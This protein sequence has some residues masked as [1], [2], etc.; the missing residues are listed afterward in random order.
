MNYIVFDLEFNQLYSKKKIENPNV[1]PYEN[2]GVSKVLLN[3][4]LVDN[5]IKLDGSKKEYFIEV[6]M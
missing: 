3:G 4:N 5:H 6:I 2:T 1:V